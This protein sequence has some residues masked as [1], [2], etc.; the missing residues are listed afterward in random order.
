[1]CRSESR[2]AVLRPIRV[3]FTTGEDW[4]FQ[5]G[6]TVLDH[7]QVADGRF[8]TAL[9]NGLT[10]SATDVFTVVLHT[11]M[12]QEPVCCYTVEKVINITPGGAK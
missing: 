2:V 12:R 8:L 1:M 5:C 10:I 4:M 9:K 3:R 7:V 6:D 11:S